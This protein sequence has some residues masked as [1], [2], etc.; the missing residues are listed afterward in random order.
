MP[1]DWRADRDLVRGDDEDDAIASI[2][3]RP[4]LERLFAMVEVMFTGDDQKKGWGAGLQRAAIKGM[5]W[6]AKRRAEADPD[7]VRAYIVESMY[8][9]CGALTIE[10]VELF[11]DLKKEPAVA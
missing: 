4:D 8:A 6:Q 5:L 10:P 1:T 3:L 9:I 2:E 11:P 7:G